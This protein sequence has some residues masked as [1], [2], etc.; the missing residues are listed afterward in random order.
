M[1][2]TAA[3]AR[4]NDELRRSSEFMIAPALSPKSVTF[5]VN[6]FSRES[7]TLVKMKLT[8]SLSPPKVPMLFWTH[9]NAAKTY[10]LPRF[11]APR[12]SASLP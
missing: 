6:Q 8:L 10:L 7:S 4:S 3:R 5:D 1:E 2:L 11:R 12:A 9:V